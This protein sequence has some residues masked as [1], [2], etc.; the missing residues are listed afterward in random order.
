[1]TRA[2]LLL[3]FLLA[4]CAGAKDGRSPLVE[5]ERVRQSAGA[6]D[7][8]ELA[9][10]AFA[11]AEDERRHAKEAQG[12]GDEVAAQLHA[13]R[14]VAGYTHAFVLARLARATREESAA[15]SALAKAQED[16]RQLASARAQIEREGEDLAKEL[17]VAR[18]QLAPPP[19]GPADPQ[20]EAARL[21]AARAL[22]TQARLLCGAAKLVATDNAS[23]GDVERALDD[24]D[25]TLDGKPKSA[26]IDQASR[27]RAQCLALLTKARR[28][29][30]ASARGTE[31]DALLAEVS[32]AGP[33]WAPARDERG[34]VV[35]L[36]GAFKGNALVP[37][38]EAK[39]KELGRVAAAHPAFGVQVVVHDAQAPT[40]QEKAA[41]QQ[42]ADACV[43]ALVAGGANATRVRADLAGAR[44]PVV[45]P[46][47]A[48]HRAR[49][50][51]VEVVF[52]APGS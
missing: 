27:L 17:S 22:A 15:S 3:A 45:D 47:D 41:D 28:E 25:K 13:E 37:D 14:A 12:Q 34:V 26:P 36:R 8:A 9:P 43:K 24:I 51:R 32:A 2:A 6:K 42:R 7:A 23:F 20:R 52:V 49:N 38:V 44:A 19:S 1:M 21:V 31:A 18:E 10:Q 35:T 29:A 16:A 50:A 46:N 40:P 11:K 4:S 5:M 48:A 33:E 30:P 39:L